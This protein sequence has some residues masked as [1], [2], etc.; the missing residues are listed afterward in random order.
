MYVQQTF[1]KLFVY[2]YFF[3][4]V[5]WLTLDTEM[6]QTTTQSEWWR[7][8][9][10]VSVLH[11]KTNPW[12]TV[13]TEPSHFTQQRKRHISWSGGSQ[14]GSPDPQRGRHMSLSGPLRPFTI[15]QRWKKY[16]GLIHQ[17][18]NTPEFKILLQWKYR[19]LLLIIIINY[20]K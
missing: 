10:L 12:W 17:C 6:I 8:K 20:Q 1:A 15:Q 5:H 7:A 3:R 4:A 19:N 14:P 2:K 9:R 16:S 18:E 11:W 13:C